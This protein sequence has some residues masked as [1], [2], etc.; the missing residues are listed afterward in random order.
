MGEGRRGGDEGKGEMTEWGGGGR[1]DRPALSIVDVDNGTSKYCPRLCSSDRGI[2]SF[3][4]AFLEK[5]LS[6][7]VQ[8]VC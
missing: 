7:V 8:T 4:I 1:H 3:A 2:S 6:L 5:P